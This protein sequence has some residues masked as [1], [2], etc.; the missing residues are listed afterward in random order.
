MNAG[1][2]EIILFALLIDLLFGELPTRHH[3]VVWMGKLIDLARHH[4]PRE[5]RRA[6]LAYGALVSAGGAGAMLALGSLLDRVIRWLPRPLARLA[7]AAVLKT[8]LS[9]GKLADA[10]NEVGS[11]LE[12]HDLRAA[13][14]L[15]AWHLVSRNTATLSE[16][17]VAAAAI[18][19]V[20]E[21]ASDSAVAPLFFYTIGGLPAALAY[22]FINT[23]DAMLGYHDA[24]RE[25]LGK[26]PARLDDAVNWL[27]ARLTAAFICIAASLLG[28]DGQRAA[29][30]W[31]RDAGKT[32]S[33]NAGHPMSAAAGAL[34]VQLEKVGHYRLGGELRR[35]APG[36]I[37]RSVRLMRVAVGLAVG[38]F[39]FLL[40]C[41]GARRREG[42][43]FDAI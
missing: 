18:E 35:P 25:W 12:A 36:D 30:I 38:F 21:N 9:V 14:R 4:A 28:E 23:A 26:V 16:S 40:I 3:P 8:T 39:S 34:G 2:P 27:P 22:R 24:E 1:R 17:Q 13:R 19:S 41:R 10:A 11:A 15:V 5:D 32:A 37:R 7:E 20:A 42:R 6:Q 43:D 33:P 31:R 29:R